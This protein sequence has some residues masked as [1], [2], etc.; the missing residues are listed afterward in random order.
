[1][2]FTFVNVESDYPCRSSSDP[3]PPMRLAFCLMA[4]L[5]PAVSAAQDTTPDELLDRV[6]KHFK[7]TPRTQALAD[8]SD[9]QGQFVIG[10][11]YVFCIDAKG[12]IVANGGFNS[13]IGKRADQFKLG[14][15]GEVAKRA[16]QEMKGQQRGQVDYDW[17]NPKTSALET[18]HVQLR[19]IGNDICG[20]GLYE[21]SI[22]AN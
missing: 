8:V 22:A 15:A 7:T 2:A 21:S 19:R 12:V 3:T 1:M 17:L 6:E 9:R 20:A 14:H 4:A 5:L 11:L 10:D 16:L 13:L 18:K